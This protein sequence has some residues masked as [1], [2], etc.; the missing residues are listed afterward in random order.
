MRI[1]FLRR[2]RSLRRY[3]QIVSIL[4]KYG[5]DQVLGKMKIFARLRL[6]K[7][8]LKKAKG[9]E[10]LTYAQRIRLA[11]E[12][13]GPTFVK[14][15]QVLSM[16]PLLIP[17]E[18]VMELTK[19]QDQVAPFP[20]AQVKQIVESELKA[21]LEKYFSSFETVPIASASP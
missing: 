4:L 13:L 5:F 15:G 20:F 12:E 18:L 11:L 14:L 6:S 1:P 7:K 9:L 10:K 16:R 2:A 3:R 8:A 19:L 17:L 21:P